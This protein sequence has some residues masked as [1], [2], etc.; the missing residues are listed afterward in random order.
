MND[1]EK[2][3]SKV[4]K[5][6]NLA[7]DAA[8]SEG[9]RDNAMRMA[10]GFLA[11]YNL[12]MATVEA[13][14]GTVEG[15]DREQQVGE[16]FGRPWARSVA[17]SV[18]KLFFCSYIY[19]GHRDAK[20][21][22]HCFVGRRSNA[23]TAA[24]MAEYLVLSIRR[25]GKARARKMDEGHTWA[26]SFSLGAASTIR[27]RVDEIIAASAKQSAVAST[28][29]SLV[30]ASVYEQERLANQQ[31]M[32]K[33]YPHQRSGTRGKS[34]G[35]ADGFNEGKKYGQTVSLNRQVGGGTNTRR[36]T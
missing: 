14:G 1:Q 34:P 19:V 12:D 22:R 4:R 13:S 17:H 18:A 6:L 20:R 33:F 31:L 30:L 24:A 25:E 26:R 7:K 3:I 8:A 9:E 36:L 27:E 23:T 32:A 16:F 10:H 28:G 15:E 35:T 5:L 21:I 2:I 11:K 29:R